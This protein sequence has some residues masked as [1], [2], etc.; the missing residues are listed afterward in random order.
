MIFN[1]L[2]SKIIFL[3]IF[4]VGLNVLLR[5][6]FYYF[7][8]SDVVPLSEYFQAFLIG[9]R[10]DIATSSIIILPILLLSYIKSGISEKIQKTYF[11]MFSVFI[12][13]FS[14][15]DAQYYKLFGN[16]FDFYAITHLQF[17]S[18][19]VGMLNMGWMSIFV[20]V[21][22]FGIIKISLLFYNYLD[23]KDFNNRINI[24]KN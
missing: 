14:I 10:F 17:F 21:A 9:L 5:I 4:L 11:I 23:R 16:R 7:N 3:G 8:Y 2:K 1:L 15:S 18:D 24:K 22:F 12:T 13:I 6:I 20:I 19:H